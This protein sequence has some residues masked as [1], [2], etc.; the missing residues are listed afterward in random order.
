MIK[1]RSLSSNESI[2]NQKIGK[3]N[4]MDPS[5]KIVHLWT[6]I[7]IIDDDDLDDSKIMTDENLAEILQD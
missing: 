6:F 3:T 4:Y 1:I 7:L 2:T 5:K